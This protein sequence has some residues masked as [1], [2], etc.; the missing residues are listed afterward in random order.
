MAEDPIPGY[1]TQAALAGDPEFQELVLDLVDEGLV[2]SDSR[3]TLLLYNRQMERIT[4][5][6]K[7]DASGPWFPGVLVADAR[8]RRAAIA[9]LRL[10]YEESLRNAEWEITAKNGQRRVVQVSGKG[11]T[12]RARRLLAVSVKDVTKE[13]QAEAEQQAAIEEERRQEREGEAFKGRQRAA[14]AKTG[15]VGGRGTPLTVL[16]ETAETLEAERLNILREGAISASQRKAQA[17][18]IRAQGAAA[19]ARGKA[20]GRAANLAAFGTILSTIGTVGLAGSQF[21]KT[22]GPSAGFKKTARK[23]SS[24]FLQS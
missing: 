6:S 14:I 18:I 4:G 13:R 5:Y 16:V 23:I 11:F 12:Y 1:A 19:K 24:G 9:A 17:G 3:G 2:V 21:G 7:R 15:V 22:T 20:A 8:T 10:A